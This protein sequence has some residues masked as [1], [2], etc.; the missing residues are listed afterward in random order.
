MNS[1]TVKVIQVSRWEPHRPGLN[2]ARVVMWEKD[3][4]D[5]HPGY[6]AQ[7]FVTHIE[8][9][10]MDGGAPTGTL[11]FSHGHYDMTRKGAERDFETRRND[12]L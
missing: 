8:Y 10:I 7:R 9:N 6:E 12:R 1:K 11:S 4:E 5:I 3:A 2:P